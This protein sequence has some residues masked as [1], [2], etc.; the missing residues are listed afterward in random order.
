MSKNNLLYKSYANPPTHC[1]NVVKE[2]VHIEILLI[3][4]VKSVVIP[5]KPLSDADV[6][7]HRPGKDNSILLNLCSGRIYQGLEAFVL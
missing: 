6:Q 3:N 5:L 1:C 2:H 4:S 7:S